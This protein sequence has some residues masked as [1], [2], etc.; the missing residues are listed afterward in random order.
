MT[1]T[2][3][4]WLL[5]GGAVAGVCAVLAARGRYRVVKAAVIGAVA[6][7]LLNVARGYL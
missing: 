6:V 1:I 4:L 7:I 2:F 3:D 5:L